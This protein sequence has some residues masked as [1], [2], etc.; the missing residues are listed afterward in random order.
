MFSRN[1]L[2]RIFICI[3]SL[4]GFLYSYISKQNKITE[5]RLEIP[6]LSKELAAMQQENVRLQYEIDQFE[7]PL[8]LM[9]LAK[10]PAYSHLKYPLLNE[11]ITIP[12]KEE[13]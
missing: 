9:E 8:A 3:L 4:G 13:K 2:I 12:V 5:L 1:L 11:I 6:R 10:Q 7:N